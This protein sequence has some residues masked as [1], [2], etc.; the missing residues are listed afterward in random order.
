MSLT[1]IKDIDNIIYKYL[2]NMQLSEVMTELITKKQYIIKK[3][4]SLPNLEWKTIHSS[5]M[6]EINMR[7]VDPHNTYIRSLIDLDEYDDD[8]DDE[9]MRFCNGELSDQE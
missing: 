5:Y 2:H 8:D 7:I 3:F 9:Y 1:G 6:V 4:F